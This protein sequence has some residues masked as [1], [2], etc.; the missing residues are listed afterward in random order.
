MVERARQLIS[1]EFVWPSIAEKMLK[2]LGEND[3]S[4]EVD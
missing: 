1:K 4:S 2:V 3:F